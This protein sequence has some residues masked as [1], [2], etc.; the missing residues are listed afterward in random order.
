MHAEPG[1]E[2]YAIHDTED[3]T[4]TLL[5]KWRSRADL[6]AHSTG[7]AVE[8]PKAGVHQLLAGPTVVTTMVAIPVGAE[9]QC[10]L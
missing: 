7:E 6:D 3:G 2:L 10:A 9:A 5:E 4:I 8:I 1:C